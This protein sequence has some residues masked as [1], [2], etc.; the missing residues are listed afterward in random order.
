[1]ARIRDDMR[2]MTARVLA[3]DGSGSGDR[4]E[5]LL[6]ALPAAKDDLVDPGAVSAMMQAGHGG[7]D[8]LHP[9]VMDLLSLR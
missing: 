1:M 2:L 9:L 4:F 5:S 8:S 6:G 3:A 7:G